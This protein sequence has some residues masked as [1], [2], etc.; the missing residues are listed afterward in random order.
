MLVKKLKN[1]KKKVM[2]RLIIY[3]FTGFDGKKRNALNRVHIGATTF[4]YTFYI[5]K[6]IKICYFAFIVDFLRMM[7]E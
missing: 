5:Y 7:N 3:F 1:V 4:Y 2:S 6:Q